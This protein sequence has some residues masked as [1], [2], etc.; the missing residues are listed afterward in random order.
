MKRIGW[1]SAVLSGLAGS[2]L[3]HAQTTGQWVAPASALATQIAEIA[4]PGQAHLTLRNLSSI[5]SEE[6]PAI[7]RLLEQYLKAHGVLTSGTESANAIEITLSESMRQRLWVAEIIEGNE[8]RVAMVSLP[9]GDAQQN[10]AAGGLTL[11][12][13]TVLTTKDQV[14]AATE[15]GNLLMAVESE[16]L[17]VFAPGPEGMTELK[18]ISLGKMRSLSRDPRAVIVPNSDGHG[19]QVWLAGTECT[20]SVAPDQGTADWQIRC[21]EGDDPWPIPN[22]A[23]A[24]E[25]NFQ[26]QPTVTPMATNNGSEA[27]MLKAFFNSARNYF[28]G[29]VSPG[30]GSELPPFYSAALIT[31]P[32]SGV[33]LLIAGID[34]KVQLTDSGLLKPITGVRDW[35]SDFSAVRTGCGTGTQIIASGSGVAISDSLRAYELASLEAVP[36]SPPLAMEGTVTALW[37]A[38]DA[39]SVFAVVR[40]SADRYEVNRVTALCN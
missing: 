36:A 38:S 15:V 17:V 13:Q 9:P 16:A 24:Q 11:R 20:A 2:L 32:A 19:V 12:R 7:S 29:V 3:I 34:G 25:S 21:R 4:G 39:K 31:R 8:T 10:R 5:P 22:V 1:V 30:L 18:R 26:A 27:L 37:P 6:L 23:V 28:T 35:G 40:S 14:L 33:A